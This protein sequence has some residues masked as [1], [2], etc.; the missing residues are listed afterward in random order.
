MDKMDRGRHCILVELYAMAH[1]VRIS[2]E[3]EEVHCLL[4]QQ[5]V[6]VAQLQD[7]IQIHSGQL[8]TG[9]QFSNSVK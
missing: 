1:L 4:C 2:P 5:A 8:P 3:E 7:H 9:I 6:R